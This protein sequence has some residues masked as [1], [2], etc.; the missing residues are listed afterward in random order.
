PPKQ[1]A[2]KPLVEASSPYSLPH[3][4]EPDRLAALAGLEAR[5]VPLVRNVDHMHRAIALAGHEQFVAM[6]RHVH[7]LAADLDRGLLFERRIDQAHGVTVE[8]GNAKEA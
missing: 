1:A 7:R 4:E 6:E 8:T 2:R 3:L 5:L